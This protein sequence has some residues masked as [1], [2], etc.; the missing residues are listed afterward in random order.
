MDVG[1]YLD[2]VAF[3]HPTTNDAMGCAAAREQQTQ[4]IVVQRDVPPRK[5]RHCAWCVLLFDCNRRRET[6]DQVHV[7]FLDALQELPG[8]R[9]ERLDVAAL[10]FG[11]DSVKSERGFARA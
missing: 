10:A 9:R 6:V 7:R 3:H 5:A 2:R 1:I 11:V 8:V 4:V